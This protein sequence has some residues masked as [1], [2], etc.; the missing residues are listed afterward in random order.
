MLI[1]DDFLLTPLNL[2][3]R[4]DFLEIVEDR[5]RIIGAPEIRTTC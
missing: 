5:Y 3:E 2:Q 1:I 4:K